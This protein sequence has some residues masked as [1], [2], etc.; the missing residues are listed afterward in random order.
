MTK[1][2]RIALAILIVII[3][4]FLLVNKKTDSQQVKVGV[5]A[6][7]SGIVADYGEQVK[8]GVQ[9][10]GT[11]TKVQFIFE[12][13]QC[14]PK[15]AVSAFKKLID[16]DKVDYIIGPACGSPQ[17]AI[18]PLLR[19]KEVLMIL[20][21][22]AAK[23]LFGSSD[24][25]VYN[26]QYSLEQEGKFIAEKMFEMGYKNVAVV[27]Y[28]NDFSKV[29]RDS[30]VANY[31]GKITNEIIFSTNESDIQ[32]ELT[33]IK[34]GSYD[35][36]FVADIAF[37]FGGGLQKMKTLGITVPVFSPYPVEL[38]AARDLVEGVF[39]SFPESIDDGQGGVFGLSKESAELVIDL[40]D[41]CGN[42]F[43]CAKQSLQERGF[44][45]FGIKN[46]SLV[47]KQIKNKEVV[48]VR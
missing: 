35:A 31:K 12:D 27:S 43:S 14:D 8:K 1:N 34:G 30:F 46:R 37:Y 20:P 39:Y 26:V 45:E 4:V 3:L 7:L 19:D 9:S 22:A 13:D 5:L 6:P 41:N 15:F 36:I 28:L 2:G 17:Q 24:G 16:L 32:T 47:L 10:V 25:K 29:E 18:A 21:S 23:D 48:I 40:V 42:N 44:D 33:K 11:S 38:P